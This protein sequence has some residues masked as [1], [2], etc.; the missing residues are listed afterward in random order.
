MEEGIKKLFKRLV[1]N[2]YPKFLDV[3]ISPYV[4]GSLRYDNPFNMKRYEIVLVIH[5]KDFKEDMYEEVNE[6]VRDI[7][8]YVDVE[9]MGVYINVVDDKEWEKIKNNTFFN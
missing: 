6:Y 4:E 8:K 3:W 1:T 5:E 9:L 7:A 2:K